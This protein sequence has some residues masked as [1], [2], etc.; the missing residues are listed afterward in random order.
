MD[1]CRDYDHDD[2]PSTHL[3]FYET[4]WIIRKVKTPEDQ[5]DWELSTRGSI[6]DMDEITVILPYDGFYDVT[7]IVYGWNNEVSKHTKKSYIEVKL[8]E[9]DF[10]TF[11]RMYDSNLQNWNNNYMTWENIHSEWNSTIYEN[12]NFLIDQNDIQSRSFHVINYIDTDDLGIENVGIEPP[13]W[14][15]FRDNNTTWDDF[16]YVTYNHLLH[17]KEKLARFGITKIEANGEIQIG[18]DMIQFPNDLNVHDFQ[19]VADILTAESGLDVSSFEYTA[20][21]IN[22]ANPKTFVDC[23]SKDYGKEGDRFVGANGGVEVKLV[24]DQNLTSWDDIQTPWEDMPISWDNMESVIR[25][26]AV[27]N[28]FGWDNV[29]VN[30][31]RFNI[32]IMI[33]LFM[34]V[35]NSKMA[36]KTEV[37]WKITNE[38]T[39]EIVL[40]IDSFTMVYRFINSGNYT[41]EVVITDTNGNTNNIKK[42]K[43]VKVFETQEF[44][45][46]LLIDNVLSKKAQ[47]EVPEDV[48][49]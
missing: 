27:E 41:I 15:S 46:K 26:K 6:E 37:H 38:S 11:Y 49:F 35:D 2:E 31:N 34:I 17:E 28:P 48:F 45:N 8:R 5:R 20:R 24:D 13:T 39:G 12:E 33:P 10:I 30:D 18:D 16:K 43:H 21:T 40:D 36:G 23:V 47:P 1:Y 19:R 14:N 4:E 7:L 32:P 29:N 42:E 22:P 3:N 25:T 44:G 9:A